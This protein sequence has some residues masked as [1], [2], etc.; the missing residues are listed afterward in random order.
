MADTKIS[1]LSEITTITGNDLTAVV[2]VS[3]SNT[4]K[5][6]PLDDLQAAQDA[7]TLKSVTNGGTGA[8]LSAAGGSNQ[9]VRQSGV[10]A[11]FTVGV[12]VRADVPAASDAAQGDIEIATQA[13]V[14]AGASTTLAV[15][16][17][18][19]KGYVD[20]NSS[21]NIGEMK[22][23]PTATAPLGWLLCQGQAIN[24]ET[25]SGLF[26]VLSITFGVGNGSTTFN[27]PDFR[28]RIPFGS[29]GSFTLAD[30]GGVTTHTLVLS[31]IPAHTHPLSNEIDE[32]ASIG[33][34]GVTSVVGQVASSSVGGDGAHNN[35]PPYLAI[36]FII[37]T[38]VTS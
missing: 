22:M 21:I 32:N 24:R 30:T 6:I 20:N 14:D 7:K 35:L 2:D 10:G 1:A 27:I 34:T 4:V 23:W 38:G 31:E 15:T 19:L 26:D 17:A 3:L 13:E 16:P 11:V 12:L 29:G 37:Y 25:Y 5:F 9:F 33:G 8:D 36:Y 28:S 18:T